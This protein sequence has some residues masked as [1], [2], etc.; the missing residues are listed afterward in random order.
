MT[1]PVSS[2]SVALVQNLLKGDLC[3]QLQFADVHALAV[4]WDK[5][6]LCGSRQTRTA[7]GGL[8]AV[9]EKYLELVLQLLNRRTAALDSLQ[10]DGEALHVNGTHYSL[11]T[12]VDMLKQSDMLVSG[13]IVPAYQAIAHIFKDRQAGILAEFSRR[14][15]WITVA[16]AICALL[17]HIFVFVPALQHFKTEVDSANRLAGLMPERSAAATGALSHIMRLAKPRSRYRQQCWCFRSTY[18]RRRRRSGVPSASA[19]NFS[20]HA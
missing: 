13:F 14:E 11:A 15:D 19:S 20:G 8:H 9:S 12:E 1:C 17:L 2:L 18:E 7:S 16:A 10:P 5:A 6:A 4:G 3:N